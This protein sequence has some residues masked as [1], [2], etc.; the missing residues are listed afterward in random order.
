MINKP[1]S[2]TE[3]DTEIKTLTLENLAILEREGVMLIPS[4]SK[5]LI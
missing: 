4:R 3:Q 1:Q 5:N 2:D